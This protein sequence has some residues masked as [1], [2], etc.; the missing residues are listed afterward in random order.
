MM[1]GDLPHDDAWTASLL[2]TREFL[3]VDQEA[4]NR[5]VA[6]FSDNAVVWTS[7]PNHGTGLYMAAFNR[8]D[9]DQAIHFTWAEL[10][11]SPRTYELRDLWEQK[12]LGLP[13][14]C[15]SLFDL[16]QVCCIAYAR[17]LQARSLYKSSTSLMVFMHRLRLSFKVSFLGAAAGPVESAGS[18]HAAINQGINFF[19]VLCSYDMT[20]TGLRR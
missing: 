11:I 6:F 9:H 14:T 12:D 5:R 20:L 4:L 16:T 10:G 17:N 8:S 1:S 18:A 2:S 7:T 3:D 19:D 13:E 15:R